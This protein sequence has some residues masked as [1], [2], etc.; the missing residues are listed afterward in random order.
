M[1][2]VTDSQ[3]RKDSLMYSVRYRCGVFRLFDFVFTRPPRVFR[4]YAKALIYTCKNE[5]LKV[6]NSTANNIVCE[7]VHK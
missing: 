7:M 2:Q 1:T 4:E 5:D 6:I 3:V